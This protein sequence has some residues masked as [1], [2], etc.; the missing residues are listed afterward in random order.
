MEHLRTLFITI[1][2]MSTTASF[3]IL[4]VNFTRFF[5]QKVPK[6]Y[7]YYLWGIVGFRLICPFSFTSM[8]SMF[9]LKGLN[10]YAISGQEMNWTTTP[11]TK[12]YGDIIF[13]TPNFH[14]ILEAGAGASYEAVRTDMRS[15]SVM[16]LISFIWITGTA[17]FLGYQLYSFWKLKKELETSIKIEG[18]I[19]ESERIRE[20]FVMGI[21]QPRIYLPIH[22][23]ESERAYVLLHEQYH[24]KRKDYLVK[25][26]A[27]LLVGVYWFHPLVWF[28]YFAL[29]KDMEMSCD[30]WVIEQVGNEAKETYSY[31]L[32]DFAVSKKKWNLE[33]L[34][35]GEVA[36]KERVK[37]V[38]TYKRTGKIAALI[39]V[40]LCLVVMILGITN[41]N[42]Q[43]AVRNVTTE[44]QLHDSS[45][46]E[47]SYGKDIENYL[48]YY[49]LY[50]D[51]KI[52]E[53]EALSYGTDYP[54]NISVTYNVKDKILYLPVE[55][56]GMRG[57]GEHTIAID[58][59]QYG[60][61]SFA[62][63]FYRQGNNAWER[64]E[65]EKDF[66]LA[67]F[68]F[69]TNSDGIMA[70]SCESYDDETAKR[71]I[72]SGNEG[73]LFIH[74]VLTD[75]SEQYE[76]RNKYQCSTF[77]RELYEVKTPYIGNHV[78]DG[79]IIRALGIPSLG[80]FTTELQTSEEPYGIILHFDAAPVNEYLFHTEMLERAALFLAVTEN[81]GY[82]EWT[83][84]DKEGMGVERRR[85]F[86]EDIEQMLGIADLKTAYTME[87]PVFNDFVIEVQDSDW[88]EVEAG[89]VCGNAA[90]GMRPY[91]RK[92]LITGRHPNAAGDSTYLVYSYEPIRMEDITKFL[93]GSQ[94]PPEKNMYL[95]RQAD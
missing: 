64:F 40:V 43:N 60:F 32:L 49:E 28:S 92:E 44:S 6:K 63:G 67:A 15:L 16:G 72:V 82:F 58:L 86:V 5:L 50:K 66:V 57:C 80:D 25:I 9:N 1:C 76:F 56:E 83:Y 59:E 2:N 11:G 73:V 27:V 26:L 81:A 62:H 85:Y 7:S 48:V 30:E 53:Y 46:L 78:A 71:S 20:P 42:S 14:N 61:D 84:P 55:Y 94:F 93:F 89:Y 51:G 45:K 33:I 18:N 68:Y 79:A 37:N 22:L 36:V 29:C 8:F 95:V 91:T 23:K 4:L 31:S 87:L 24:I 41:G 77:V 70:Y 88:A 47:F 74:L 17:L 90:A 65:L 35:F 12:N 21:F 54:D 34:A 39:S 75:D 3:V 10:H 19:F 38:L 13:R 52:I 69:D